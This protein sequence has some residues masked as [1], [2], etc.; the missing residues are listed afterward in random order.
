MTRQSLQ[1]C[2]SPAPV[3]LVVSYRQISPVPAEPSDSAIPQVST[4]WVRD[5]QQSHRGVQTHSEDSEE[6]PRLEA[7]SSHRPT[8]SIGRRQ[9]RAKLVLLPPNWPA[10]VIR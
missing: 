4:C 9:D 6:I 1:T 5:W 8:R 10:T 7:L 3:V 2:S